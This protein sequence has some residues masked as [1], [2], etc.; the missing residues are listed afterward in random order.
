M[1]VDLIYTLR[2]S[3][4]IDND[5]TGPFDLLLNK[6]SSGTREIGTDETRCDGYY[7][8]DVVRI[9]CVGTSSMAA[10]A[11]G[12]VLALRFY[13]ENDVVS[14]ASFGYAGAQAGK[15]WGFMITLLASFQTGEDTGRVVQARALFSSDLGAVSFTGYNNSVDDP[16][17]IDIEAQW[18]LGNGGITFTI[19]QCVIEYLFE[20]GYPVECSSSSSSSP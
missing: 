19:E 2:T 8:G 11:D 20:G 16:A 3:S 13:F 7:Q 10:D 5:G 6:T 9:T 4:T 18:L 1:D 17:L 15:T 12:D 14:S